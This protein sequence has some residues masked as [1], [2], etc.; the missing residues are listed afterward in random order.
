MVLILDASSEHGA[1]IWSKFRNFDFFKAF[2]YIERVVK[3][4][5][6]SGKDLFYFIRAQRVMNYHLIPYKYHGYT[7]MDNF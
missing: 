5:F 2:G 6:F 7:T 3:S 1:H 4:Y